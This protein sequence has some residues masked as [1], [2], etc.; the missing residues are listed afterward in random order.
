VWSNGKAR[1]GS[2]DVATGCDA[3]ASRFFHFLASW[4]ARPSPD[5]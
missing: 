3:L 4:I 5:E 2:V 1:W